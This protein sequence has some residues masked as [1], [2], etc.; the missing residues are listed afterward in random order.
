MNDERIILGSADSIVVKCVLRAFLKQGL[1]RITYLMRE[2]KQR[3]ASC[4]AA[5]KW[6]HY[7]SLE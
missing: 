4:S 6:R 5:T 1:V 2:G 3:K 7:T